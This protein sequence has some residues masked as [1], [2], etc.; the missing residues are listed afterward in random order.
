MSTFHSYLQQIESQFVQL[1]LSVLL[2]NH[3]KKKNPRRKRTILKITKR[4]KKKKRTTKKINTK[5]LNEKMLFIRECSHSKCGDACTA[6]NAHTISRLFV[7]SNNLT[8]T[9]F[10]SFFVKIHL[11][12]TKEYSS[13]SGRKKNVTYTRVHSYIVR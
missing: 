8:G 12:K 13:Q 9:S 7:Q 6:H 5:M 10:Q 11:I 2:S 1:R 3:N 4:K